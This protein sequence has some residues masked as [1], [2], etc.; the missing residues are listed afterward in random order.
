MKELSN[1]DVGLH[2]RVG[3][4]EKGVPGVETEEQLAW[5]PALRKMCS[6]GIFCEVMSSRVSVG[7]R[8]ISEGAPARL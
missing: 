1:N 3:M 6:V 2:W 7:I 8:D 5:V 4:C